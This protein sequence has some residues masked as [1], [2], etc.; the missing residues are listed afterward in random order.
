MHTSRTLPSRSTALA[1]ALTLTLPRAAAAQPAAQ[2][3][4][5]AVAQALFEEAVALMAEQ[6]FEEACPKLAESQRLDPGGGTVLNLASCLEHLGQ[7]ASA[8]AMYSDALSAAIRDGRRERESIARERLAA[9]PPL[10]SRLE[11]RLADPEGSEGIEVELD[12]VRLASS[13]WRIPLPIDPG[14][15]SVVARSPGHVSF[16]QTI[17]VV[18]NG[19]RVFVEVPVLAPTP[20]PREAPPPAR[21]PSPAPEA[22][23]PR[24][25]AFVSGAALLAV[26]IG[27]GVGA[28]V[29]KG[30]SD[31][32]CPT[33]DTCT[34]EGA[35]AMRTASALAWTADV[36]VGLGVVA[37]GVGLYLSVRSP[38]SPRARV[39]LGPGLVRGSF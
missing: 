35:S 32:G 36:A 17:E 19:D 9:L 38:S 7:L 3:R 13:A 8:Y 16:S 29:A 25:V 6:R 28:L 20:R 14:T 26:G 27:A 12:G 1:L 11:V 33:R 2:A 34:P 5:E 21:A 30:E 4:T 10:L 37:L 15:H 24:T 31:D 39:V 22:S 23:G 18:T